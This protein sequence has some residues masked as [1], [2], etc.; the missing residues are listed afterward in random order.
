MDDRKTFK[1]KYTI[2]SNANKQFINAGAICYLKRI[3]IEDHHTFA[4]VEPVD[5]LFEMKIPIRTFEDYF[6]P[7]TKNIV[8]G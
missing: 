8:N 1:S 7:F 4:I 5:G 2:S 6:S 3:H